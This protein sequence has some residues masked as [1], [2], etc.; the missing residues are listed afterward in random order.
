VG[1]ADVKRRRE[2]R[3]T[4]LEVPPARQAT[5]MVARQRLG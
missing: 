5:E 1:E 3:R 4:E 2:A